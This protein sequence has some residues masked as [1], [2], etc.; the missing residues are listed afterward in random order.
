[1]LLHW[2]TQSIKIDIPIWKEAFERRIINEAD[3]K[4]RTAMFND[5]FNTGN[6]VRLIKVLRITRIETRPRP[7]IHL[8]IRVDPQEWFFG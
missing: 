8:S 5:G 2:I 4:T 1:M 6:E 3:I 7:T